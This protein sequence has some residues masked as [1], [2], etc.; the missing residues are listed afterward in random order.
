[1]SACGTTRY[2]PRLSIVLS[3]DGVAAAL[4][5]PT[6]PVTMRGACLYRELCAAGPPYYGFMSAPSILEILN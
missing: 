5:Y 2:P 4:G 3:A 1:M 6:L